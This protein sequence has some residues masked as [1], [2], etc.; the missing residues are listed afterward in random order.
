MNDLTA[1]F[2]DKTDQILIHHF[3]IAGIQITENRNL[4]TAFLAV[5]VGVRP[6]CCNLLKTIRSLLHTAN[7]EVMRILNF[8]NTKFSKSGFMMKMR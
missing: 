7:K 5:S 4:G 3:I 2:F 8:L 6:L 1:V